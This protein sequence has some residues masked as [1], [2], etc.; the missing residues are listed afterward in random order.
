[1]PISLSRLVFNPSVALIGHT[2]LSKS[3]IQEAIDQMGAQEAAETSGTPLNNLLGRLYDNGTEEEN[4]YGGNGDDVS[5]FSARQCYRSWSKGRAHEEYI[6][7]IINEGH[8]S[9]F[10]HAGVVLQITGISRSLSLELIRHGTGTGFSQESQRY[11]DAKD[12]RFVVPPLLCEHLNSLVDSNW[13]LDE[14]FT[15]F[16]RACAASLE[17]YIELQELMKARLKVEKD[18]GNYKDMTAFIKRANEA[19]RSVLNNA[20]ETRMVF[21]CN[22]RSIRHILTLRGTSYAD[23]EIRRLSTVIL[24]AVRDYAP[25]FFREVREEIGPD[26]RAIIDAAIGKL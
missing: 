23:L 5:E 20:A 7:N 25:E 26:G 14:E 9:V 12:I 21:S 13:D 2:V 16:R 17:S 4:P 22:L 15:A 10:Q 8:G 18:G 11:V 3:G 1:M 6:A 19:S 24:T